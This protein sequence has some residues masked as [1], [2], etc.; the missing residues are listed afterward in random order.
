MVIFHSYVKLPERSF[1]ENHLIRLMIWCG[2]SPGQQSLRFRGSTMVGWA[3]A[4]LSYPLKTK[5]LALQWN[6]IPQ[7]ILKRRSQRR[8]PSQPRSG[9]YT[10][11]PWQPCGRLWWHVH[12][13]TRAGWITGIRFSVK[14]FGQAFLGLTWG[15]LSSRRACA[16]PV[17]LVTPMWSLGYPVEGNPWR[18]PNNGKKRSVF[19]RDFQWNFPA[20]QAWQRVKFILGCISPLSMSYHFPMKDLKG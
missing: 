16:A 3:N 8:K 19:I 20:S 2:N 14:S 17:T 13:R 10:T 7:S 1:L 9:V 12:P 5:E 15:A 4:K 11:S 18:S 6:P